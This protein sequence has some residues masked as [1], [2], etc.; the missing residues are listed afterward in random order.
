M[1]QFLEVLLFTETIHLF[2]A[3]HT[4]FAFFGAST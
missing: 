4:F 3:K 1:E 2:Q